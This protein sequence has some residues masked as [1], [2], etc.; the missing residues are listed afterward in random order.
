MS[1]FCKGKYEMPLPADVGAN[2]VSRNIK[3]VS[4]E[5]FNPRRKTT[6]V[7]KKAL[8]VIF[9]ESTWDT[10][11]KKYSA[12]EGLITLSLPGYNKDRTLAAL[13]FDHRSGGLSGVG[14]ILFLE[15]GNGG[16]KVKWQYNI[17]IS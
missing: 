16:W 14:D 8:D 5:G 13:Y 7:G 4:L 6:L 10:F 3:S 12:R 1:Y 2:L 11:Y 9:K 15:K 17:W